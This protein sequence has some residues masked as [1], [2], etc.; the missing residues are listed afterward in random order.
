MKI[1]EIEVGE[2]S[3]ATERELRTKT[4]LAAVNLL[5]QPCEALDFAVELARQWEANL[6]V[7]Y[8]YSY[9]PRVAGSKL[10]H[11]VP[12]VDWERHRVSAKLYRLVERLRE[13][14]PRTFAYFTDNDCPA[15]AIQNLASKLDADMII[16]SAHDKGW[17]AK[18][19]LYSDADDI[20][21][22]STSPVLVYRSKS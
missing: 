22:R 11:A 18:L 17:L 3:K 7:T 21:R 2:G 12:S 14:Y 4:I 6:Y 16:V 5:D 13:R 20:T 9:L 10:V 15:E 19:L 8:V 1:S